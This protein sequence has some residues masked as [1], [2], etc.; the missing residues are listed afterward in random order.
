MVGLVARRPRLEGRAG[1]GREG[2]DVLVADDAARDGAMI[3]APTE[4]GDDEQ[5]RRRR[6]RHYRVS[7][8][9]L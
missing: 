1:G 7:N 8:Y 5:G 3:T 9:S 6:R 2:G 4:L